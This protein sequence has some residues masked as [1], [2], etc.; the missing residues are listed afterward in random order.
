V[1][2]Y[3]PNAVSVQAT[4]KVPPAPKQTGALT[5]VN[6]AP[7]KMQVTSNG[8]K[9]VGWTLRA[10]RT[11]DTSL[12]GQALTSIE[13]DAIELPLPVR[14][15]GIRM[16]Q[17]RT[18]TLRDQ[19]TEKAEF[20]VPAEVVPGASY[21][22]LRLTPSL[23]GKM[24]SA[25]DYLIQYPY[26]CTEQTTSAMFGTLAVERT[27]ERLGGVPADMQK[28]LLPRLRSGI[29]RLSG[30]QNA[31]G[32]WG[33]WP[34]TPSD[35]YM[36]ADAVMALAEVRQAG[37][38]V[39]AQMLQNG[40]AA[41]LHLI[42]KYPRMIP[43]LL[44]YL[45]DAVRH[46]GPVPDTYIAPLWQQ[47]DR[48][49]AY[50]QASLLMILAAQNDPRAGRLAGRLVSEAHRN[51]EEVWWSSDFD[52]LLG[53]SDDDSPET[54]AH[55]LRA[56]IAARAGGD[57][58]PLV[59]RW[60]VN[61]ATDDY[62]FST[63]QTAEVMQA[64]AAYLQGS[65]ELKPDFQAIVRLNGKVVL[66]R[67]FTAADLNAQPVRLR[68][69]VHRGPVQLSVERQGQGVLYWSANLVT[70]STDT[71]DVHRGSFKLNVV[72]QYYRLVPQTEKDKSGQQKIYYRS[73]P[74]SGPLD[75]G[76]VILV[77][78]TISGNVQRY[79]LVEDPIPAGTE[80]VTYDDLYP[81]LN[82]AK[83]DVM[84]WWVR[85]ELHD[86]R[87]TFFQSEFG[88][89]QE[90]FTY[91]LRVNLPGRF[92]ALPTR[93]GPMYDPSKLATGT[94]RQFQFVEGKP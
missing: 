44:A 45:L 21:V 87:V 27:L 61:H 72:R 22:S 8:E 3:L 18:G 48:L 41:I 10:T 57:V 67:R 36:T 71:D 28:Q 25:L 54:T 93:V 43:P 47:R 76:D 38:P 33:W 60:L 66:Q 91:L 89:G 94:G 19:N 35:P 63:K 86:N 24:F 51:A 4:L 13:S 49:S 90:S 80:P 23:A 92:R 70:F 65:N 6:P 77:R 31:D 17:P 20:T 74:I 56:L 1:H 84:T 83:T 58:A 9:R 68:L 11:G 79:L 15:N 2:N 16:D 55:V 88:P 12:L 46:T 26:G 29:D 82:P 7:Q 64:L 78:L 50:G 52:P 37:F 32:G 5:I 40:R 69:P 42:D 81:L 59:V 34:S 75:T 53:I 39:P 30:S 14:P 62:W 85:R 73:V